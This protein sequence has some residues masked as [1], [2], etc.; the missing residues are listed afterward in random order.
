MSQLTKLIQQARNGRKIEDIFNISPLVPL[1]NGK[2]SNEDTLVEQIAILE[3]I[4]FK[5]ADFDKS[6]SED[7]I[8]ELKQIAQSL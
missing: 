8:Y 6:H 1:S 2:K 4:L 7:L 3:A 5:D